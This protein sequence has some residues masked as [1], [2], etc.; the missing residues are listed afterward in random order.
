[1]KVKYLIPIGGLLF[2]YIISSCSNDEDLK[3]TDFFKASYATKA[4][5]TLSRGEAIVNDKTQEFGLSFFAKMAQDKT[6]TAMNPN[7]TYSPLSMSFGLAL[8]AN[9]TNDDL[10]SKI[11]AAMGIENIAELNSLCNKLMRFLPDP[12]NQCSLPLANS[13]WYR[14][15]ITPT[16][17][18]DKTMTDN[19]FADLS[20]LDFDAANAAGVIN[21][22]GSKK[23][24]GLINGIVSSKELKNMHVML[25]NAM[26]FKA[27]WAYEFKQ[28]D[29]KI[30]KF[31]GIVKDCDVQMMVN[32]CYTR[33]YSSPDNMWH[34]AML[35][36]KGNCEM[37]FI[38]PQGDNSIDNL[39]SHLTIDD[40][41]YLATTPT[42]IKTTIKIP[43]F[44]VTLD[45]YDCS[46]ILQDFGIE[47]SNVPISNMTGSDERISQMTV[48]HFAKVNVNESGTEAAAVT[49]T[50]MITSP[51]E[52]HVDFTL[53]SPF[54]YFIRNKVTGTI[55]MAGRYAQP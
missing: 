37:V 22:W 52:P 6:L 25:I 47:L 36:Y 26:Y 40:I 30:E 33:Y 23:T 24:N 19:F 55:I 54:L 8:L 35:P 20:E 49:I 16:D 21:S 11:S 1:M 7:F 31:N 18:Y 12:V 15:Y 48:N 51:R 34:G 43:R 27:S 9:S 38:Q 4:E 10:A 41:N 32:T 13:V 53:D 45:K 29:T 3:E 17:E 44:S 46:N 14:P 42:P 50:G 28:K 5:I 39:I 2:S